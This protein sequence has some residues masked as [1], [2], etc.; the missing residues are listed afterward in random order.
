MS[1]QKV[2]NRAYALQK[3]FIFINKSYLLSREDHL[4]WGKSFKVFRKSF[5]FIDTCIQSLWETMQTNRGKLPFFGIKPSSFWKR[6]PFFYKKPSS[7]CE[8][9]PSF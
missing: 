7:F 8:R 3:G 9:K 1:G 2:Q 6:K 4:L 5:N